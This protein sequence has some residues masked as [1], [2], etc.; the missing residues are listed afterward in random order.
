MLRRGRRAG[1]VGS[2]IILTKAGPW[3]WHKRRARI[4]IAAAFALRFAARFACWCGFAIS[5]L[6]GAISG[7]HA[8]FLRLPGGAFATATTTA[9]AASSTL[10]IAVTTGTGLFLRRSSGQA[11]CVTCGQ[12]DNGGCLFAVTLG[13]LRLTLRGAT[14]STLA[15]FTVFRASAAVIAFTTTIAFGPTFAT[16]AIA[17]ATI[18]AAV[19]ISARAA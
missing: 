16:M 2:G 5:T 19:A 11:C 10:G 4:A 15:T 8:A 9:S 18:T 14:F 12:W 7:L 17:S 1:F 13:C 3:A 6:S